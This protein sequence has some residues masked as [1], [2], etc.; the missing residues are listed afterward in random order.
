MKTSVFFSLVI[1]F[2]VVLVACDSDNPATNDFTGNE[3]SYNLL[4]GTSQFSFSGTITFKE[5]TD[6]SISAEI[7]VA[8]SG[9]GGVHPVHLHFGTADFPDAQIAALFSP[10]DAI[11]GLSV[12][13]LSVLLDQTE[14]SYADL[15]AFDGSVKIHLDNGANKD[16]VLAAANI[17]LN[18]GMDIS[19]ITICSSDKE[20]I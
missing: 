16:V 17:G 10:V 18:A 5:R 12:T 20:S 13:N 6:Q 2:G 7:Q 14:I 4:P 1:A 19:D 11:S 9:S 15:L 8:A 3:V